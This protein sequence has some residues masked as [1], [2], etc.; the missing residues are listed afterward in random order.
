MT[1]NLRVTPSSLGR[2]ARSI[3]SSAGRLRSEVPSLAEQTDVARRLR[4]NNTDS[5]ERERERKVLH[6]GLRFDFWRI[7][8]RAC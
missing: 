7:D 8:T 3:D 5:G 1:N 2:L 6:A 4:Y